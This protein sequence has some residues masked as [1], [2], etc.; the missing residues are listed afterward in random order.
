MGF[1][2]SAYPTAHRLKPPLQL[3]RCLRLLTG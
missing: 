3:K 1:P 2:L